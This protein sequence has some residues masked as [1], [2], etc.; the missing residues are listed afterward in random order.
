MPFNIPRPPLFKVVAALLAATAIA[1]LV[2]FM[3]RHSV[4]ILVSG[5]VM[6]FVLSKINN[7]T[8]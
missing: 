6:L 5:T 1:L 8:H 7:L 2:T 4:T 3:L